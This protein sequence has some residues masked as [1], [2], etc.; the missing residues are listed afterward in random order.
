MK[1][2]LSL[3]LLWFIPLLSNAQ[4]TITSGYYRV[5]CKDSKRYLALLDDKGFVHKVTSGDGVDAD[6]FAI[7]SLKDTTY[8]QISSNPATIIYISTD[9]NGSICYAQGTSTWKI[10]KY[11]FSIGWVQGKSAYN[12]TA[13]E[14]SLHSSLA[15]IENP[16][17]DEDAGKAKAD[18]GFVDHQPANGGGSR[19]WNVKALNTSDNYFGFVPTTKVGDKY[20]QTFYAAFPFTVA[21][22]V[23]VYSVYT[24]FNGKAVLK[25]FGAGETIPGGMPVLVECSSN[26]AKS[27]LV[28]PVGTPIVGVASNLPQNSLKGV[29]FNYYYA[30]SGESKKHDNRVAYDG[31]TMRVLGVGANGKL[32]FVKS[33]TLTYLPANKAYLS[34]ENGTPDN[35][36]TISYSDYSSYKLKGDVNMDGYTDVSDVQT[37]INAMSTTVDGCDL[38]N[39]GYVDIS[40]VQYVINHM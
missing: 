29:Y 18:S 20:Y 1:N 16:Y 27:N 7:R 28:T 39:D 15:L 35:V 32:A 21:S 12:I 33:S 26:D 14:R 3:L 40:D 25:P 30:A 4:G 23:T 19:F 31:N 6:L 2:Y 8:N 5:Q 9:D 36:E 38:N 22:G 17:W 11:Y 37:V 34:V 13:T 24:V 10:A